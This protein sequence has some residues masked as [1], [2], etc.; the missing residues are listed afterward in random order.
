MKGK[1][2]FSFA[3]GIMAGVFMGTTVMGQVFT[4]PVG[5]VKVD[6]YR[7]GLTMISVPLDAADNSLNGAEGCVGDMLAEN[8]TGGA[9]AVSADVIFKWDAATQAYE[10]AFLIDGWGDPFD[11][12]WWDESAGDYSQL[13]FEAGDTCWLQRRD[14]APDVATITFLGWVPMAETTTLTMVKGLT[15]FNW[16]YP[17]TLTLNDSTLGSVGTGGAGAVSADVVFDWDG[18]SQA[19]STAFLIDGWGAPFD[20]NWWDEATS[21]Y[22]T[23]SFAPGKAFWY[24][25]RPDNSAVWICSRP[26]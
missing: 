15:M 11:G 6:A 2:A 17:T 20:G 23:I 10:T 24:L 18:A 5:F 21:D 8:L 1:V 9:G 26:Y 12:R 13:T 7:N 22:S 25:R 14:N 19:Y 16:P 4:D 3:V